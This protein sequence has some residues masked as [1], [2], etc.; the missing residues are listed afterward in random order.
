MKTDTIEHT[1]T[2][3][4]NKLDY[5]SVR[6]EGTHDRC[7]GALRGTWPLNPANRP[8]HHH[9]NR[10]IRLCDDAVHVCLNH[11]GFAID[12]ARMKFFVSLGANPSYQI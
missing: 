3:G 2:L 1:E 12:C 9:Q 10:Q 8:N 7:V 5:P 11:A 6:S 4:N